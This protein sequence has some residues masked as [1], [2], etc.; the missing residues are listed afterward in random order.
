[1][2]GLLLR[3]RLPSFRNVLLVFAVC[4]FPIHV[5]AL[6]SLFQKVPVYIL[7]LSTS[8]LIGIVAYTLS[9]ALLESLLLVIFLVLLSMALPARY[10]R[11]RFVTQGTVLIAMMSL[12]LIPVHYQGSILLALDANVTQYMTLIFIWT[13]SFV[14]LVALISSMLRRHE[15]FERSILH[16]VDRVTV[17]AILYVFLDLLSVGIL[18]VRN[19]A[20]GLI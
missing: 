1:V 16:F 10:F 19:I 6:L 11:S 8:D 13:V 12:W 2:S 14:T 15:W 3:D 20:P 5:W 4:T 18:L 9:F 7:R 17:L